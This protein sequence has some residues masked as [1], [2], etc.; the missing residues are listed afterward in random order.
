MDG[1]K[2]LNNIFKA[3]SEWKD[4]HNGQVDFVCSFMAFKGKNCDVVDDR[5]LAYGLK[6]NLR[7]SLKEMDEMLDKEKEDF[8][9]W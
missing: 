6:D 1:S 2:E 5:L 4:K 9:N 7:L 3:I 8:V